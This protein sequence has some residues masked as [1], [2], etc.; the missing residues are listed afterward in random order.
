MR[1]SRTI[2]FSKNRVYRYTL[3]REWREGLIPGKSGYVVFIGLNPSTANERLDDHTIRR[4][5]GFTK[6]WGYSSFCMLNLFAFRTPYPAVMKTFKGD[7]VGEDNNYWI[8]LVCREAELIVAAWGNEGGYMD[9]DQAVKRLLKKEERDLRCL[10]L[11]N[12]GAPQHPLY[13]PYDCELMIY[14]H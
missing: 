2:V 11:T 6:R 10:Q 12:E 5:I 3:W 1:L 4:C 13:V 8:G 14:E 9:R 7:P